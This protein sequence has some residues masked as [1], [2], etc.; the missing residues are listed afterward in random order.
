VS[1][2]PEVVVLEAN[3]SSYATPPM[4]LALSLKTGFVYGAFSIPICIYFWIYLPETK[5]R[6]AAEIDELYER[7]VPAWKWSKTATAAEEQMRAVI[8]MKGGVQGKQ[9]AENA[10][11]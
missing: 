2:A 10:Q 3:M 9:D 7:K 11:A 4:L 8:Q 6:S 1:V 5:K